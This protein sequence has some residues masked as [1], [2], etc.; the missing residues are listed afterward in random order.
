MTTVNDILNIKWLKRNTPEYSSCVSV[1]KKYK[2]KGYGLC[3]GKNINKGDVVAYYRSTVYKA[4][5]HKRN[6]SID[7]TFNVYSPSGNRNWSLVGDL[8]PASYQLPCNGVPYWG[9]LI[10]EPNVGQKSNCYLDKQHAKNFSERK[11]LKIGDFVVYA[12]R[13]KRNIKKG[14]E[15][16]WYYGP[17]YE[18]DY[19]TVPDY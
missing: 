16:M 9:Y 14:E 13:A 7:Y 11:S 18:R 8:T 2:N 1:P 12:I 10:N 4:D 19:E 6:T 15:L 3:A 17:Y 5:G